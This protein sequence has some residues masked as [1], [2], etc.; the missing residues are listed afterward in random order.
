M[1]TL[2]SNLIGDIRL[3]S[4]NFD[5]TQVFNKKFILSVDSK[6]VEYVIYRIAYLITGLQGFNTTH[7]VVCHNCPLP[8]CIHVTEFL[9]YNVQF[10]PSERGWLWVYW[11]KPYTS[12]NPKEKNSQALAHMIWA[13][14]Y[15]TQNWIVHDLEIT[16]V[17]TICRLHPYLT[18]KAQ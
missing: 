7:A 14:K 5:K 11:H 17:G 16:L 15:D 4:C 9:W 1:I 12:N 6:G 10:P 8:F 2:I 3:L 13:A 18:M